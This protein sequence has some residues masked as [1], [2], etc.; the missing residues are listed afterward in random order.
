M[1]IKGIYEALDTDQVSLPD[2]L[3][4]NTIYE[5]EAWCTSIVARTEDGTIIHSRNLDFG[6]ADS[7]RDVT[8][9]ATFRK[10]GEEIFDAVMFAGTIG[11]YTGERKGAFSVSENQRVLEEN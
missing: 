5:L 1:E 8:F 6:E 11:V 10:D 3:V 7:L 2:L 9:H 4:V